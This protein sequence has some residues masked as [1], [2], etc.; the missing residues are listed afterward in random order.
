VATTILAAW[1]PAVNAMRSDPIAL[2]R[3][4]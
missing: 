3:D 1:R 4:N 2:L